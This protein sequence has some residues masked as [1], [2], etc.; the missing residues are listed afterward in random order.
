MKNVKTKKIILS[1]ATVALLVAFSVFVVACG[2]PEATETIDITY[3]ENEHTVEIT[4]YEGVLANDATL[5]IPSIINGKQVNSISAGAFADKADLVKIFIPATV[6]QIGEGAF[7]NCTSLVTVDFPNSLTQIPANAFSGCEE[8]KSIVIPTNVTSVGDKAFEGCK[9]LEKITVLKST[10]EFGKDVFKNC[11]NIKEAEIPTW[12]LPMINTKKLE[13]LTITGGTELSSSHIKHV[14]KLKSINIPNFVTKID[15][16]IFRDA[17]EIEELTAPGW[18]LSCFALSKVRVLNVIG[19]ATISFGMLKDS[20]NIEKL[21][22]PYI[23]ASKD[24]TSTNDSHIGYIFGATDASANAICIPRSL[25]TVV[26]TESTIVADKAFY[27]CLN[28]TSVILPSFAKSVGEEAFYGCTSLTSVNIPQNATKIGKS[29]FSGTN[30]EEAVIPDG[31]TTIEERVFY[32]CDNLK[33]LTIGRSVVSVENSAFESCDALNALYIYDIEKWCSIDFDSYYNNPLFYAT[34]LYV[35]GKLATE[36]VIPES[37]T[38]IKDYTFF[39][40]TNVKSIVLHGNVTK[41]GDYAFTSCTSVETVVMPEG[42]L[43]IGHAAFSNCKSLKKIVIPSSVDSIGSYAF[44]L[45]SSLK[46]VEINANV[47]TM[48]ENTFNGCTSISSLKVSDTVTSV[49]T[50]A[51]T[52]CEKIVEI[53]APVCVYKNIAM[54]NVVNAQIIG[55]GTVDA[56]IFNATGIIKVTLSD[57]ITTIADG[58]FEDCAELEDVAIST[59]SAL[60]KIGAN[61]FKN[62]YK[63]TS[64]VIPANINEVADNAFAGCYRLAV[65]YNLSQHLTISLP[66]AHKMLT[67]VNE[68]SGYE[69]KNDYLFLNNNDNVILV[70]YFGSKNSLD[71]PES[72]NGAKYLVGEAAF[73]GL[74]LQAITIPEGIVVDSHSFKG[75]TTLTKISAPANIL[76]YIDKANATSITITAGDTVAVNDIIGIE[77]LT[78]L[79]IADSITSIDTG[80]FELLTTIESI[81]VGENNANF[82]VT[83]DA[84]YI[85]GGKTLCKVL[86]NVASFTV[87]KSTEVIGEYAFAGCEELAELLFEEGATVKEIPDFAFK[88]CHSLYSAEIPTSV[89]KIGVGIFYGCASLRMLDVADENTAYKVIG[90]CLVDVNAGAIIGATVSSSIPTEG[91]SEIADYAFAGNDG[92]TYIEIPANI[93]KISDTA[94]VGTSLYSISV[95]EANEFYKFEDGD[96]IEI[97]TGKIIASLAK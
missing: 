52:G 12:V 58:A 94:F 81:E 33:S 43:S 90:G 82:T 24:S 6:T 97:A 42:L 53:T 50:S 11:K 38:E 39:R 17:T 54:R 67:D 18:S 57:G 64:I 32:N 5:E 59:T 77:K 45:C 31:V 83:N 51:F 95:D 78:S 41:I 19:E 20:K 73:I 34:K 61:A 40:C 92:I 1:I 84:L 13:T 62:C 7:K 3:V 49:A 22:L 47:T 72:Y 75:C 36:I 79:F 70:G 86:T 66:Y 44:N 25:K 96:L 69:T 37:I 87:P 16:S 91:V 29:A 23:G 89:E 15:G 74:N 2:E 30:I 4:G 48:Q 63:L 71:L 80:V 46:T 14:S 56:G 60:K 10:T 85:S 76:Q 26:I 68:A 8:L 55:S 21:T 65:V 35:N 27:G 9:S 88:N 93:T 28:I